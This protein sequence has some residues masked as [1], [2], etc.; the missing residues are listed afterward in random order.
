[1]TFEIARWFVYGCQDPTPLGKLTASKS[2]LKHHST[3]YLLPYSDLSQSA[4]SLIIAMSLIV[5]ID[6]Y[7]LPLPGHESPITR[8]I[9]SPFC[10]LVDVLKLFEAI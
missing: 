5:H 4:L 8:L 10:T 2:H 9:Q 1:M 3:A 6:I 7:I